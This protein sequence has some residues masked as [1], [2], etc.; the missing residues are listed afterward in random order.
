VNE[1][2][3]S[4]ED[5]PE[6]GSKGF[7]VKVD[8]ETVQLFVVRKSGAIFGYLNDCPHIGTPLNWK[9]TRFLSMDGSQIICATHG[10]L[11]R[12]EDGHCTAGPCIGM[13]L[14]R[15]KVDCVD[16]YICM[17]SLSPSG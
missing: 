16:D 5:I 6:G 9:N 11:F 10:A 4:L 17:N 13:N 2:L 7:E 12:I 15:V 1:R 8:G 3:C 14:K